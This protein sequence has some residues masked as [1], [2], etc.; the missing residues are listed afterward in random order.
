MFF[1]W[2]L[3]PF[4]R[5]VRNA[6]THQGINSGIRNSLYCFNFKPPAFFLMLL[7]ARPN[8]MHPLELLKNNLSERIPVTD[9]EMERVARYFKE[10]RIR[11][12]KDFNREGDVCRELAFICKGA[13]RCYSVDDKGLE[14][15]SRFA[16]EN[17]WLADLHSFFTKTPSAYTIEAMEETEVLVISNDDLDRIHLEVPIM[18]RF[19]RKLFVDAYTYTLE[20]LNSN[21]SDSVEV[22]YNKLLQ[23]QP[24]LFQRVPL[25]YIA[26]FLGTT[27]ETVSRI[28]K[29][30]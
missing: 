28:R 12:K 1:S 2:L 14:H 5:T 29:N 19:F 13:L 7:F 25:T 26:S 10:K 20:R 22:R 27:P 15:I 30:R 11:K 17:Y 23:S 9:S 21:V 8:H 4:Q 16:F 6:K 18:E 24:H 3:R